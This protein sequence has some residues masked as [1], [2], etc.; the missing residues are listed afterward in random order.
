MSYC[1]REPPMWNNNCSTECEP[2]VKVNL[3][4]II[5]VLLISIIISDHEEWATGSIERVTFERKKIGMEKSAFYWERPLFVDAKFNKL[6]VELN[7]YKT[8]TRNNGLWVREW[9]Y[10]LGFICRVKCTAINR[11]KRIGVGSN[12]YLCLTSDYLQIALTFSYNFL[13]NDWK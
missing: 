1:P 7:L 9:G 8:K 10:T 3:T 12:V 11:E 2:V 4:N 5:S 6:T 13:C